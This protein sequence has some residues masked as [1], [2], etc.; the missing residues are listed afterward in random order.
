[1]QYIK[2]DIYNMDSIINKPTGGFPNIFY[3]EDN[4]KIKFIDQYNVDEIFTKLKKLLDD[5]TN[6]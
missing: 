2:Y 1:M 4:K 5:N 6:K 3:I